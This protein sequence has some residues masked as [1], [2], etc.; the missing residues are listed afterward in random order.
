MANQPET[1]VYDTGVVQLETTTPV[2]G[3][4]GGASNA[5]LLSLANRTAYL[6]AHVDAIEASLS[7]GTFATL[8]SPAFSGD[9]TAPTAAA[10]DNDTSIAT[11]AFVQT[12]IS[13]IS[14][15]N[16][17]GGSNVTLSQ[18]Q[19]GVGIVK[20][21][22]AITADIDVIFPTQADA[23]TVINATSGSFTIRC[24]T[25]AGSGVFVAQGKQ[26]EIICDAANIIFASNDFKDIA[27]TG[28]PTTPTQT[29]GDNTTKVASTAF[30]T[31]AISSAIAPLAT[32]AAVTS[33]IAAA[34][35][36]LAPTVSPSFSGAPTA[37]TQSPGDNSTRLA[38]T[39]F[40]A[41]A[42]GNAVSGLAPAASPALTGTPTAP[43][44]SSGDNSTKVATTAFVANAV[45]TL[46]APS[47]GQ[48]RLSLVSTNLK[49][50][51]KD[52]NHL[53]IGGAM[54]TV[55]SAGVTLP[56]SGLSANVFYY[57]YA[58]MNSATMTLEASTTGHSTD[59]TTGV[60]IKTGD[61][62]RTLVGAVCMNGSAAFV[63]T[64][65]F[66]G[67]ISWFNPSLKRSFVK[68]SSDIATNSV[69]LVELDVAARNFFI[70]FP[71][72]PVRYLVNGS[73]EN[74]SGQFPAY[75]AVGFDGT[76]KEPGIAATLPPDGGA[77]GVGPLMGHKA[78]L[79]ENAKHYVTILGATANFT[80]NFKGADLG[81]ALGGAAATHCEITV[82]G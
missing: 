6:K 27:L 57:I 7:G 56:P 23:W 25:A 73:V 71:G 62:S 69:N 66:I 47:H 9:P 1:A 79:A 4:V 17:A 42:V 21:T 24:K 26:Q 77:T 10:G 41:T 36:G 82:W 72:R 48:C 61:A 15:V 59:A 65:S 11:T 60:E 49:L 14:T 81:D 50:L 51:P 18:S 35:S 33:A 43:T 5:P 67:V 30:V 34:V 78:G 12:A 74:A 80:A 28:S 3:G 52:G 13:G 32:S 76:T 46:A 2:Q 22:G 39:A 37:P 19:W 20:L 38:T 63:D 31:G 54:Q 75:L 44:P 16:V 45:T 55:P 40:V 8:V 64:D 58:F 68:L 53:I 29:A 70:T